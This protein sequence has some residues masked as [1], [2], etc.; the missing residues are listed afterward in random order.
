[1]ILEDFMIKTLIY[2]S[3]NAVLDDHSRCLGI[4]LYRDVTSNE[5]EEREVHEKRDSIGRLDSIGP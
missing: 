4:I 3:A 2:H 1:V 5:V